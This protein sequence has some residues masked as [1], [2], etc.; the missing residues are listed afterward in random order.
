M[1][2]GAASIARPSRMIRA[3]VTRS[4]LGPLGSPE[5]PRNTVVEPY[6]AD[7]AASLTDTDSEQG[8]HCLHTHVHSSSAVAG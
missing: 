8:G 1:D 7:G 2:C 3:V 4:W 6:G 5:M